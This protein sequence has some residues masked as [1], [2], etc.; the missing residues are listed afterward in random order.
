MA[1]VAE[2][3]EDDARPRVAAVLSA[4]RGVTDALLTLW[5]PH[6]YTP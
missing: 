3:L 4:C 2:I 6:P 1:R 5:P